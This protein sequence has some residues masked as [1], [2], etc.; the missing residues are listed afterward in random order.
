MKKLGKASF[1][2]G[3]LEQ[4]VYIVPTLVTV[5]YLSLIHI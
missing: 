4:L 3:L 1:W 2:V 5:L